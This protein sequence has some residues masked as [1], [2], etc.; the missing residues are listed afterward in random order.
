MPKHIDLARLQGRENEVVTTKFVSPAKTLEPVLSPQSSTREQKN[1]SQP[2]RF[3]NTLDLQN[4]IAN[5]R[6]KT[7]L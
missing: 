7:A 5:M 3:G 1:V 4:M 6:N 2:P